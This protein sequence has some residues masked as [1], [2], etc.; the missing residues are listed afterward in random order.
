MTALKAIALKARE[1]VNTFGN[2]EVLR[3][4]I[5]ASYRG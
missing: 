5:S 2:N 4:V 3:D 1:I